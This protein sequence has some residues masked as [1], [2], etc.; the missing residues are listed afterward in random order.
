MNPRQRPHED[1]NGYIDVNSTVFCS[2]ITPRWPFDCVQLRIS[3]ASAPDSA[4][5]NL[6]SRLLP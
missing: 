1:Y 4:A 3:L 6:V 5:Q 2:P